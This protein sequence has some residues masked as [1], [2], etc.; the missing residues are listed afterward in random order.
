MKKNNL[1]ISDRAKNGRNGIQLVY[2]LDCIRNSSRATDE[3]KEFANDSEV[4]KFFFDIFDEEFNGSYNKKYY[5]NLQ[6]RISH[7]LQGLPSSRR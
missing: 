6:D 4:L 7:Y 2:V 1:N 3:G 5:P